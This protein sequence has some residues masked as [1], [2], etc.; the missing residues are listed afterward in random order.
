MTRLLAALLTLFLLTACDNKP[1]EK[2]AGG[3][4]ATLITTT[5]VQTAPLEVVG[6]LEFYDVRIGDPVD[7]SGFVYRPAA[8]GLSD[9]TAAYVPQLFP[10]RP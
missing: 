6:R 2:K 5:T 9:I 3:P 7:V 10:L 1:E 8:E 4:P